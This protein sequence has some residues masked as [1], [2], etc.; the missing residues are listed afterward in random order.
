MAEFGEKHAADSK[1]LAGNGALKADS[2][3]ELVKE[4]GGHKP[5]AKELMATQ[6]YMSHLRAECGWLIQ[7]ITSLLTCAMC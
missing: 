1:T 6:E 2:E 7:K 5:T 4:H 3:D